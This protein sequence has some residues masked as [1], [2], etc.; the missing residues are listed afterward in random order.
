MCECECVC[1]CVR[2]SASVCVCLRVSLEAWDAP[3]PVGQKDVFGEWGAVGNGTFGALGGQLD[4][5]YESGNKD[6]LGFAGP[7]PPC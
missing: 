4:G 1:V 3:R 7:S 6:G 5:C 2:V